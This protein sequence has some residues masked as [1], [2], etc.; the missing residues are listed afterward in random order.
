M[1]DRWLIAVSVLVCVW[2][3]PGV[4][5]AGGFDLLRKRRDD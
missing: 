3:K 4:M 5:S 1:G 2:Y